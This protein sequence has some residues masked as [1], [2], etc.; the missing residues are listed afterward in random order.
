MDMAKELKERI[1][2]MMA[3]DLVDVYKDDPDAFKMAV[4]GMLT[5]FGAGAQTYPPKKERSFV[6][7]TNKTRQ[8]MFSGKPSGDRVVDELSRA[9]VKAV[10]GKKTVNGQ[11]VPEQ[12]IAT[13]LKEAGPEVRKRVLMY[14]DNP[15]YLRATP[16]Q[17]KKWLQNA[18]NSGWRAVKSRLEMG[19]R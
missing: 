13:V 7:Q 6:D 2:P 12:D 15:A 19:R 14:L 16:E 9:G 18:V 4:V 5:L 3:Q 10:L 8:E 1:V 11:P 17:R